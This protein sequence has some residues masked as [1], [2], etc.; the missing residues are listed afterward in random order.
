MYFTLKKKNKE[1]KKTFELCF[2][3]VHLTSLFNDERFLWKM[4]QLFY[5]KNQ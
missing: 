4:L 3:I 1:K 5:D 2:G